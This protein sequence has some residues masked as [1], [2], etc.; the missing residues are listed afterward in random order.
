M[1]HIEGNFYFKT[2]T[3][4]AINQFRL[5]VCYMGIPITILIR[6]WNITQPNVLN[7]SDMDSY[8]IQ[9][10]L[11][12]TMDETQNAFNYSELEI[13]EIIRE[14]LTRYFYEM[15]R[16]SFLLMD[17][18]NIRIQSFDPIYYDSSIRSTQC[19]LDSIQD[20]D[21]YNY[22]NIRELELFDTDNQFNINNKNGKIGPLPIIPVIPE[23][24]EIKISEINEKKSKSRK[25]T[26]L[27]DE[28]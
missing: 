4:K 17:N 14:F 3:P 19:L 6:E 24:H 16:F 25:I 7:N 27:E 9:S 12:I 23:T 8:T 11:L 13:K 15:Y 20:V 21:W 18:I 22:D 5:E 26:I 28:N 1:I 10:N 2:E